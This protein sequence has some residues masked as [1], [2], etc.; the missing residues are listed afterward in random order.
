MSRQIG[1][2]TVSANNTN[3]VCSILNFFHCYRSD[4]IQPV[5]QT[6]QLRNILL[7][8]DSFLFCTFNTT[9]HAS[10]CLYKIRIKH[11]SAYTTET[12]TK[13]TGKQDQVRFQLCC[14][15]EKKIL[16]H[17]DNHDVFVSKNFCNYIKMAITFFTFSPLFSILFKGVNEKSIDLFQ[18]FFEKLYYFSF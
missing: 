7:Q 13:L 3:S 17:C 14:Y 9:R 18:V 4:W 1:V 12:L 10:K 6:S 2:S 15:K 5:T 11:I 16:I 8:K